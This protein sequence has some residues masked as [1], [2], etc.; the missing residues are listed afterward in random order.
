MVTLIANRKSWVAGGSMLVLMT[1]SDLERQYARVKFLPW[2]FVVT[3]VP[4]VLEGTHSAG[5]HM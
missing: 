4:F 1:L 5:E 2:I 3:L